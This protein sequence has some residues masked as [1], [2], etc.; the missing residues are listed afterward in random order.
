MKVLFI[1][2]NNPLSVIQRMPHISFSETQL[3]E[4]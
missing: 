4:E 3:E 1:T 2:F